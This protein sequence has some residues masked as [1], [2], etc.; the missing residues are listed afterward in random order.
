MWV[1]IC[2]VVRCSLSSI[3]RHVCGRR[4]A[5]SQGPDGNEG[6]GRP[7]ARASGKP[8]SER[9]YGEQA[10]D[11]LNLPKLEGVPPLFADQACSQEGWP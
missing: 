2:Q 6:V 7:Q 4:E 8:A 5:G 3:K 1:G 10:G 9:A 11:P